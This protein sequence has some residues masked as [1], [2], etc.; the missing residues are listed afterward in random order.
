MAPR[1]KLDPVP[2]PVAG[3]VSVK[4]EC[5]WEMALIMPEEHVTLFSYVFLH[6]KEKHGID[7]PQVC[8]FWH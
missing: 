3:V 5:G 8:V 1:L 2:Q 7:F 6:L 4:C